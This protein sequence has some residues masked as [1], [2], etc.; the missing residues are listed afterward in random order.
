VYDFTWVLAER[1]VDSIDSTDPRGGG[2]PALWAPASD[3][4]A[5][6]TTTNGMRLAR[7]LA[8]TIA[9]LVMLTGVAL[10]QS[11]PDELRAA[12]EAA[13]DD[14]RAWVALGNA[15][16]DDEDPEAAK[17]AFLEAVAVDY[18]SC[19]GHYGLG[20][21]EFGR[22]DYAAAL[23]AFNE[24]TR[25]CEERFDGH[26]NR[27][28]TLARL[29]RPA[30]A[31]EAFR[32]A[33]AQA[34]PEASADDRVAAWVGV[35]G[36][37]KGTGDYAA[38]A[39]AYASA[40]QIRPT[41]DELVFLQ[42][43]ALWRAGSGLDALPDLIDL[44]GRVNDYRV[45]ALIADIYVGASQVDYALRFLQR[46]LNRAE[47]SGDAKARSNLLVKLGL[48]QRGLGRDGEAAA[49]FREAS[50]LDQSSWE[51]HYNLGVSLL[52]AGQTSDALPAL[53][54][55]ERLAPDSGEVALALASTYDLLGRPG[56]AYAV[57]QRALAAL[58]DEAALTEARFIAG[59]SAYRLGDYSAA[60]E[61]LE[62]VV[63]ARPGD[64][65]AQLWAGLAAYQ[66]GDYAG[67]VPYYERAVQLD[68]NDVTARVNLGAAYLAA[69]RYQDAET[70]YRL[71]VEQDGRD[72]ESLY[73]LGWSLIGQERRGPARDVWAS[74]CDLGY[75]SACDA[76]AEYF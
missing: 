39:S 33:I 5:G 40:L 2:R 30:E 46:A 32:E 20:L 64:A 53:E 57:A 38:A 8:W 61:Q 37:R 18:R 11:S 55:A 41:D 54:T 12:A 74:A 72:T 51:A 56:E 48:L 24:V 15:L 49:S 26:Y 52:E 45:S 63:D 16:L 71:L 29:R 6:M 66:Q 67:A 43:D 25:L 58:G 19:D 31:A 65:S 13:A 4:E 62:R 3:L 42:G 1:R 10:A 14:P 76:L 21:A 17:T 35:A 70:V 68:P 36:Q 9:L 28:V 27:G 23:F 69:E 22:G 47:A 7:P 60:L 34:E 44:E 59:R 75:R 50:Q 73:N